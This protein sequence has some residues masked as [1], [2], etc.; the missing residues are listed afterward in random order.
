MEIY[1]FFKKMYSIDISQLPNVYA[2]PYFLKKFIHLLKCNGENFGLS[3]R[4]SDL[5]RLEHI[6]RERNIYRFPGFVRNFL[7]YF[8]LELHQV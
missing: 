7:A 5:I 4:K 1:Q 6:A 8:L 3:K 2:A